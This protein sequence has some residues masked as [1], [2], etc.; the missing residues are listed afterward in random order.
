MELRPVIRITAGLGGLVVEG[1]TLTLREETAQRF[2]P[3]PARDWKGCPGSLSESEEPTLDSL[4]C[5]NLPYHLSLRDNPPPLTPGPPRPLIQHTPALRTATWPTA[6][7][8][9]SPP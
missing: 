6:L 5:L 9:R 8:G 7:P 1:R 4:P 2:L 3:L